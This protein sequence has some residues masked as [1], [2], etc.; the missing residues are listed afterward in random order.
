VMMMASVTVSELVSV[1][2]TELAL[3]MEV[4]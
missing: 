4:M 1:S 2:A 3:R